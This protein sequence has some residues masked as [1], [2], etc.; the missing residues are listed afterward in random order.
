MCDICNQSYDEI[1]LCYYSSF[2]NYNFISFIKFISLI[3]FIFYINK[4]DKFIEWYGITRDY[5]KIE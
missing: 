4:E 2:L 1:N 5:I 3:N